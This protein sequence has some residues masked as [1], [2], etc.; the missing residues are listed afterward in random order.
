[1]KIWRVEF[2]QAT[3]TT[4][5]ALAFTFRFIKPK[6]ATPLQLASWP[7]S[8]KLIIESDVLHLKNREERKS[9]EFIHSIT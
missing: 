1:M 4:V 6:T 7:C 2:C 9:F 5:V 3:A 8:S